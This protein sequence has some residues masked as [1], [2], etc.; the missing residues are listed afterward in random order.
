MKR[1]KLLILYTELAGYTLAC[2]RELDPL[3]IEVHLVRWQVNE[4][5]PFDFI[6]PPNIT[7]YEKSSLDKKKLLALAERINP[8][9]ILCSGWMDKDYIHVVRKFSGK[10]ITILTMDNKWE[11]T[12]RQQA[13]RLVTK[14]T[15]TKYFNFIWV[16]GEKQK[17]FAQ[18]LGF[19]A[20]QIQ[21]G[22]YSADVPFFREQYLANMEKKRSDFPHRMIYVG[23][24]YDFKG[25]R[26]LWNA[27]IE[28]KKEMNND[29]ELWCLGKGDVPPIEHP[30]IKH[31]G[32]VQPAKMKSFISSCGVYVLPSHV[33]PWAV[34]VHEF[35]AAGFPL[36][37]SENVGAASAFLTEGENGFIFE[38]KDT[39]SIGNALK[40]IM[41]M[42]NAELIE[43]GN[44]SAQ[45]ALS[46][47]PKIWA[48]QLQDMIGSNELI[49]T[50]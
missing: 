48:E 7:F 21:T 35:A 40:K 10:A 24:Y 32:F 15:L 34:A 44:A 33:E 3:K 16:P 38:T 41:Q 27:F 47:T 14:F 39:A 43:M 1:R 5:A 37:L 2:L 26:E 18:K 8:D 22:F 6:I 11:G 29:W 30:S 25:I 49:K 12:I 23:R 50:K 17:H 42:K 46:I 45:K 4:E 13:A 9:S 28:A 20:N 19:A 36:L 31:F